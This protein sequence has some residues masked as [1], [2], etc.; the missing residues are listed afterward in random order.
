MIGRDNQQ[1]R[2]NLMSAKGKKWVV[3]KRRKYLDIITKDV[4]IQATA[5]FKSDYTLAKELN[6][7]FTTIQQRRLQYGVKSGRSDESISKLRLQSIDS[8]L[9]GCIVG[10]VLGDGFLGL[11]KEKTSAYLSISHGHAQK[12]WISYKY[13]KLSRLVIMPLKYG[14]RPRYDN[15]GILKFYKFSTIY[16]PDLF[17]IYGLLY[18]EQGKKRVTKEALDLLTYE[19]FIWWFFD[20]GCLST[21]RNSKGNSVQTNYSLATCQLSLDEQKLI[22]QK[23]FTKF[24]IKT[25]IIKTKIK[26]KNKYYY[27]LYFASAT[28]DKVTEILKKLPIESMKYKVYSPSETERKTPTNKEMIQSEHH[29][30]A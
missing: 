17:K 18:D 30:R 23:L 26:E 16:H 9:I 7:P 8:S 6:V 1:E 2:I 14:E 29:V 4:L 21:R 15:S 19:G 25:S 24:G 12:D 28:R 27:S 5:D 3:L 20:D 11:N 10:T 22:R 13:N